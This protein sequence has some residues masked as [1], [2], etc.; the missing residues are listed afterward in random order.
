MDTAAGGGA[1]AAE[2][3]FWLT[4]LKAS[5]P[6]WWLVTFWMYLLPTAQHPE[7]FGTV[8]FWLGLLYST[9][10]LNS[11]CNAHRRHISSSV[12]KTDFPPAAVSPLIQ[13][14]R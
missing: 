4:L 3:S 9:L 8:P 6:G 13:S 7:V 12:C 11:E 10:P 2:P 14:V 1:S 5:R